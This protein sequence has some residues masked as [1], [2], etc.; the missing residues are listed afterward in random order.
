[1]REILLRWL[2]GAPFRDFGRMRTFIEMKLTLSYLFLLIGLL[3]YSPRLLAQE[4]AKKSEIRKKDA[5]VSKLRSPKR[6]NAVA[7]LLKQAE[8]A[9]IQQPQ[10]ALDYVAEALAISINEDDALGEAQSYQTLGNIN[11]QQGLYTKA[12]ESYRKALDGFGMLG[13]KGLAY[14]VKKKLAASLEANGEQAPALAMWTEVQQ[15][16]TA[17]SRAEDLVL[18][19]SA[20]AR[21]Y[22]KQGKEELALKNYQEVL[23][24]EEKRGNSKGVMDASN[25]IGD[26]YLKQEKS[27]Q[28]LDYYSRSQSLAS[29]L[30]DNSLVK[31]NENIGKVLRLEK[32][33]DQE[34][35]LRQQSIA[36]NLKSN[37][38]AALN[39]EYLEVA[40]LYLE[41][42]QANAA[43]PFL[44]K[45]L[46]LSTELKQ[47]DK[48]GEAHRALSEAYGQLNNVSQ[49]LAQY[50]LYVA[51]VDEQYRQ[52]E[53]EFS[54]MLRFNEELAERQKRIESLE[55]DRQLNAKTIELLRQEQRLKE[56]S[57]Q[58]QRLLIYGLLLGLALVFV[59]S[60]LLYKSAQKRRIANQLLALK[61]LRSQ[62]NPHFIFNALN[63]VNSF[64]SQN[65]ERSANKYLS[66]FSRLMRAVMENSQHDFVP[67]STE[68]RILELYLSLE[69]FRFREK[70]DYAFEVDPALD[71]DATQIPP[72]LIQP[73]IENAVWHGLR[74]KESKG[75][76]S[77]KVLREGDHLLVS[78]EDDGIGRKKS[79]ALKTANQ[80]E[81]VSTGL[82]NIENRLRI[83]NEIHRTRLSVAIEDWVPG[84][85]SGT[86]VRIR[87]PLLIQEIAV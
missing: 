75:F 86:R 20:I 31:S 7:P 5:K 35:A 17:T 55:K 14:E 68:L 82:R 19:K 76:L 36:I 61:S 13:E 24:M 47:L 38:R 69:H 73:Y 27:Q 29:E 70:F 48:K 15:E 78:V 64:I 54:G 30:D 57:M 44:R 33:Y 28:A 85:E 23:K 26:V 77:V 6:G 9:S 32:R 41:Q 87:I 39:D 37:N 4:P 53:K 79:Q 50:K 8:A 59:A 16:A 84:D 21:I 45:S 51:T 25:N 63:S 10:K 62:M 58:K 83:L 67:L 56:E 34:L 60:Y 42:Q 81:N 43:L 80:R 22:G 72:M 40:R 66:E 18:A 65:D 52:K 71:T 2:R 49:A 12:V 74:Y 1:M 3:C 46:A 11:Q